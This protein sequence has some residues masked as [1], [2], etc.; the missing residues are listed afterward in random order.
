MEKIKKE[1]LQVNIKG[2][3]LE[4]EKNVKE[5]RSKGATNY[6]CYSG[7]VIFFCE[8]SEAEY[9][10]RLLVNYKNAVKQISKKLKSL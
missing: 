3:I 6:E 10:Q 5:A 1:I 9:L 7:F 2:D 4:L 8:E